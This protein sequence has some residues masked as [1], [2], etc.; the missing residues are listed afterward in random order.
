M[1]FRGVH[2]NHSISNATTELTLLAIRGIVLL[3]CFYALSLVVG[4]KVGLLVTLL[5]HMCTVLLPINFVLVLSRA[6]VNFVLVLS[7]AHLSFRD[8][9]RFLWQYRV[10]QIP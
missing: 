8:Q 2:T 4:I 1:L 9:P 3:T 10:S 7:R 5:F 6:S